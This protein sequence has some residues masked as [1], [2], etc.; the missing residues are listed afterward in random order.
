MSGW[1]SFQATSWTPDILSYFLYVSTNSEETIR[2]G[3][4][5]MLTLASWPPTS[6]DGRPAAGGLEVT[7][8]LLQLK[9]NTSGS[10][11]T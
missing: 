1:E 9:N 2:L 7:A 4:V 10:F 3:S 11:E 5:S 6:S 8:S